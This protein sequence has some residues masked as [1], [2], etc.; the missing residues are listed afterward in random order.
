MPN[1]VVDMRFT[2]VLLQNMIHLTLY[3]ILM[4]R[5]DT[6]GGNLQ[7]SRPASKER[8]TRRR[9]GGKIYRRHPGK[10]NA[11]PLVLGA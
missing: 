2:G 7:V 5:R 9:V 8:Y 4:F 11:I 10:K 1:E 3:C 6:G